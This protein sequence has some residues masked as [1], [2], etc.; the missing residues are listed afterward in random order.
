MSS[1]RF[2]VVTHGAFYAVFMVIY[3]LSPNQQVPTTFGNIFLGIGGI[4]FL[5][6]LVVAFKAESWKGIVLF[7]VGGW[8]GG[9][10]GFLV[11]PGL[12]LLALALFGSF[13]LRGT[14]GD[15][16][17]A[18]IGHGAGHVGDDHVT[19]DHNGRPSHIGHRRITYDHTGKATHVGNERITYGHDG[20]ASYVG[21]ERILFG[22]DGNI[23]Q[24][25]DARIFP[26]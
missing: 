3:L 21:D 18:F 8:L 20:R 19:H 1:F 10:L 9:L 24:V 7:I 6:G 2:G 16:A 17:P 5:W 14:G 4:A 22:Q 12:V 11:V 13:S 25:G 26:K 15:H 23:R